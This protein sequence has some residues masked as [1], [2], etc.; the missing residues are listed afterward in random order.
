[1]GITMLPVELYGYDYLCMI[2]ILNTIIEQVS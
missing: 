2:E 1:M